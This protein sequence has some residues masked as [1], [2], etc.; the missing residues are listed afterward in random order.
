MADCEQT[1]ENTL[2]I[3]ELFEQ[4]L[5]LQRRMNRLERMIDSH[6]KL[7]RRAEA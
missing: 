5:K 6:S 4:L 7:L 3:K 2:D 1:Q